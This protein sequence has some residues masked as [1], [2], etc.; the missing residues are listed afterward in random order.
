M[1]YRDM[2]AQ[3]L[4]SGETYADLIHQVDMRWRYLENQGALDI[5][6]TAQAL[7][8]RVPLFEGVDE[9]TLQAIQ[10]VLKPRLAVPGQEIHTKF[11]RSHAMYFVASGAV[12]L[13]LPDGTTAELGSGQIFG[14]MAL[15]LGRDFQ[16][17]VRSL[18][19]SRLLMLHERDFKRLLEN[20][21]ALREKIDAIVAQRLRA[22]EVWQQFQSGERQHEPLPPLQPDPEPQSSS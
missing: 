9:T 17:R 22:V 21:P 10:Q 14:E 19:Y 5:T 20:L 3:N 12:V 2:L 8:Q 15:V 11:G 16:P 13:D 7:I 1:R 6:L 4:I 18:G